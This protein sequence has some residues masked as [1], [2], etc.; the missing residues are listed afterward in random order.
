MPAL[1]LCGLKCPYWMMIWRRAVNRQI[2]GYRIWHLSG[3]VSFL[4]AFIF[5][6]SG[7][8]L[9]PPL[10]VISVTILSVLNFACLLI[11]A[12]KDYSQENVKRISVLVNFVLTTI[13]HFM[14]HVYYSSNC[15]HNPRWAKWRLRHPLFLNSF[16]KPALSFHPFLSHGIAL[17]STLLKLESED[18]LPGKCTGKYTAV[19][20]SRWIIHYQHL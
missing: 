12:H 16:G 18:R 15:N 7:S 3:I 6:Y 17:Y 5:F 1:S 8:H 13:S 9:L 11:L 14:M 2:R 19:A 20:V 4:S 10:S